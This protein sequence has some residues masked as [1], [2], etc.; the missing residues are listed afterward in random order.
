M[1]GSTKPPRRT[2]PMRS[3]SRPE[4]GFRDAFESGAERAPVC[5]PD[6]GDVA[7]VVIPTPSWTAEESLRRFNGRTSRLGPDLS[8]RGC[9]PVVTPR[10]FLARLAR[11]RL[12][13]NDISGWGVHPGR[14]RSKG[15]GLEARGG[16]AV[17]G[18]GDG[19][20]PSPGPGSSPSRT[21]RIPRRDLPRDPLRDRGTLEST[22][23]SPGTNGPPAAKPVSGRIRPM[24][25]GFAARV[26]DPRGR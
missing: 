13:R 2:T 8:T 18:S 4:P 12:A 20:S 19:R 3:T 10:R 26:G 14:S 21:F 16:P 9:R 25:A 24:Q 15:E 11:L 6:R 1:V 22:A 7:S 5:F 23:R 17:Q